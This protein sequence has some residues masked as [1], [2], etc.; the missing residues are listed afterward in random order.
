MKKIISVLLAIV[1]C[2]SF[3]SC[4]HKTEISRKAIDKR[5]TAEHE[6]TRVWNSVIP[7]G[8]SVIIIPYSQ[9]VTVPD[10]YEVLY[11]ITYD[12]G[13]QK[14][15]WETITETEYNEIYIFKGDE[16]NEKQF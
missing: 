2:F 10:K 6:E 4:K 11:L 9:I 12:N 7:T 1:F 15:K 8:K 16:I 5:F 13:K 3:V 14:Q